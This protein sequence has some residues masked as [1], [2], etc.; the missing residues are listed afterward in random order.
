MNEELVLAMAKFFC[1]A[2]ESFTDGPSEDMQYL[3]EHTELVEEV[4]ATQEDVDNGDTPEGCEEGDPYYVL[5]ALG[6][7]AWNLV[8]KPEETTG[9]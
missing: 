9:E 1:E 2:W 3:M 4:I 7:E 8:H 5:S 6:Q